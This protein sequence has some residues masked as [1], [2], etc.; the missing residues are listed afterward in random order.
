MDTWESYTQKE[1][2]DTQCIIAETTSSVEQKLNERV[3]EIS[4]QNMHLSRN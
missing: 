1:T 2:E 4:S 3:K